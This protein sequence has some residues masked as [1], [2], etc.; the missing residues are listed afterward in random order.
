MSQPSNPRSKR[1]MKEVY[2]GDAE[3]LSD[4]E[5][6]EEDDPNEAELWKKKVFSL[7]C[8]IGRKTF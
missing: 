4:N 3:P 5:S 7:N 1:K 6:D 2:E 8:L